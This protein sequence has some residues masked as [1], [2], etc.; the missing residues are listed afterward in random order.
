MRV[1]IAAPLIEPIPPTLYGGSE[2]VVSVVVEG[3]VRR[4]HD[5]TLFASGDSRTSATLVPTAA[6]SLR[7]DPEIQDYIAATV[8]HIGEVYRRADDFDVIHNHVDYLAFPFARL[9]PVPTV[10]TAH[11]RL[12]LP[13]IQRLFGSFPE[14]RLVSISYAQREPVPELNWIGNVY[15]SIDIDHFH[16]RPAGGDYLVFLGRICPEKRP[17]R[18]IEIARDLDMPLVIAAKVDAVD[19]EYW[20]HAIEPLVKAASNITYIGEVNEHQKDELLGNA[21]AYLFPIDWPEPFGLTMAE[22][23]A[24]GTPVVAYRAGSTPE[25]V[26][27]GVTGFVC[28]S[29]RE[30]LEAVEKVGNLDRRA[31]REHVERLFAPD[32]MVSGYEDVY[33]S[34]VRSEQLEPE[35]LGNTHHRTGTLL[36]PVGAGV[37]VPLGGSLVPA[38]GATRL[39]LYRPCCP[40]RVSDP[41]AV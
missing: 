27:D 26:I 2:R 13:E 17:D 11:G 12:D 32:V 16:F 7:L 20:E 29:M 9:S 1:A 40:S 33:A 35:S 18:A 4:G 37:C 23:M 14:Q 10:T 21:Y 38:R 22:S 39:D 28:N 36:W 8:L 31:C 30:M 19:Q 6:R 3:L 34:I 15:N 5:V 24:T 25:I 41:P